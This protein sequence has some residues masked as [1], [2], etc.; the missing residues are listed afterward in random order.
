MTKNYFSIEEFHCPCGYCDN[1]FFVISQ[2]LL[3]R[4]NLV[5]EKLQE[6]IVINSGFRC[7]QH[8]EFVGGTSDSAHTK[9]LA[10]DIN[11][12]DNAYRFKILPLLLEAF[13]RLGIYKTWIHVDVETFKPSGV[14]WV[15]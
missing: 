11:I 1:S 2:T 5:R 7:M 14:I 6:P 12:P 15:K 4:L 13:D 3:N 9:G 10:A 8:N